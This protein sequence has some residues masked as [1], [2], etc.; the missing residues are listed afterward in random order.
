MKNAILGLVAATLLTTPAYAWKNELFT[1]L[2][3]DVS[4]ELSYAE[5]IS[6]G[7][8]TE[9]KFF[10]YADKDRSKGLTKVEYFANR[11][12]LGRCK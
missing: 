7:C 2:D 9:Q 4:G 3:T 5:L 8:R 12:V 1:K 6:G 10:R 11:D